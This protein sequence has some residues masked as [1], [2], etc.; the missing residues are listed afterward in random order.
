[1]T[2][3]DSVFIERSVSS[4]PETC[5]GPGNPVKEVSSPEDFAFVGAQTLKF[6]KLLE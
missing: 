4:L 3:V 2:S 1:M 5:V 6:T